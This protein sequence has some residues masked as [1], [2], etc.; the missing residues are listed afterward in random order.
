MNTPQ[1][2]DQLIAICQRLARTRAVMV[3][4]EVTAEKKSLMQ[5]EKKTITNFH[6]VYI[7]QISTDEN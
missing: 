2:Q 4:G 6:Y 7:F 5:S 1:E 3:D